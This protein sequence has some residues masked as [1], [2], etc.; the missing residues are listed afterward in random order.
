MSDNKYSKAPVSEVICGIVFKEP[1]LSEDNYLLKF[2]SSVVDQFPKTTVL[3]PLADESLIGYQLTT[4]VN[5]IKSGPILHRLTS[6]NNNWLIQ[7]QSD[8]F[9]LNWLRP[10]NV[11]PGKYPGFSKIFE[12]FSGYV[13]RIFKDLNIDTKDV[14]AYE[15]TYLDRISWQKEISNLGEIDKIISLKSPH[16]VLDGK[17][18]ESNGFMNRY[19]YPLESI[20]GYGVFGITTAPS[21]QGE[22]LLN[23]ELRLKGALIEMSIKDWFDKTH[24]IQ[25]DF[26]EKFFS[27]EILNKWK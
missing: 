2:I 21:I 14:Q 17:S 6:S 12:E 19:A 1:I 15:L 26:F 20:G 11:N 9:Y 3:G 18:I 25:V 16:I 7:I 8:K 27:E 4:E 13:S 5:P 22:Q 24:K 10:D 23:Y